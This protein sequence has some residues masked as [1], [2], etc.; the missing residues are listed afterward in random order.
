MRYYYCD[1]FTGNIY[2]ELEDMAE[3]MGLVEDYYDISFVSWLNENY[4]AMDI[5][6]SKKSEDEWYDEYI[7][8]LEQEIEDNQFSLVVAS[9]E[10]L[11]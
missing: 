11:L 8:W 7:E 1:A 10:P 2:R 5:L 4:T 9:T 3:A 6:L